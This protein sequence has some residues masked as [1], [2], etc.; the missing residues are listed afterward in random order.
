[1]Q[2][3]YKDK[4]GKPKTIDGV[5]S[6]GHNDDGSITIVFYT[7]LESRLLP[8]TIDG[9]EETCSLNCNCCPYPEYSTA[10]AR[11]TCPTYKARHSQVRRTI[12]QAAKGARA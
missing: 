11:K 3:R 2:L 12:Y 7:G 9:A 4:H 8:I 10:K 5:K 6:F 1:M